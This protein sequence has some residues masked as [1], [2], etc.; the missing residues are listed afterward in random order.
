MERGSG[1]NSPGHSLPAMLLLLLPLPLLV[2]CA[3]VLSCS[4]LALQG[5]DTWMQRLEQEQVA[6]AKGVAGM[7]RR[8][9]R[10][11][12]GLTALQAN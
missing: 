4:M 6:G 2:L 1:G 5:D 10:Q 12:E 3:N 8:W 9:A 7:D 11:L